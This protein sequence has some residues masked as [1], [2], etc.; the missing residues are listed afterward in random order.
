MDSFERYL[1]DT[2]ELVDT[3]KNS[4]QGFVAA[5][6]DKR[7]RRLCM[8]KQRDLKSLPIYRTLKDSESP[9][10]PKLYG[11]FDRDEK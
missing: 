8:M 5:V 10:V 3:L 1:G 11:L 7:A 9:H 6:Y 2:Y 4:E